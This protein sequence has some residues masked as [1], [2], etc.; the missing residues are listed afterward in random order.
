MTQALREHPQGA[1]VP[2]FALRGVGK[3]YPGVTALADIDL[4]AFPG[5]VLAIC[6]A[7]GAG[8]STMAK[9]IAGQE[10]PSTGRVEI[11]G[12]STPITSPADAE[13]AGVLLM[14]QEP[15]VIEDFTVEENVWLRRISSAGSNRPW[16]RL[17]RGSD[18]RTRGALDAVGLTDV[19]PDTPAR[20]LGPGPR[21]MLAL[22]RTQVV[23]HRV[24]LLDETTASTTEEHFR[25]VLDLV[26]RERAAGVCVVFVSH[27][28]DEVFAMADRIAVMR[29]GRLVDVLRT[30]DTTPGAVIDLMIGESVAALEPLSLPVRPDE[31]PL[32]EV[33]DLAAGSAREVTLRVGPGEVV[34]V[35][36]LV[37]S[38]R[39][40]VARSITGHQPR[41]A[42]RVRLRGRDVDARSPRAALRA[43]LAYLTEDRRREGFVPAF[44][45]GENMTLS[46]LPA[47]AT[48]GVLRGGAERRRVQQLI[49]EFQVKGGPRTLTRT[50]SGGNQQKVILAKWLEAA[51][52]VLVL[53]EPT[54]G[55]D[56]GA[57]ANIYEIVRALAA[58]GR[59]VL[60]VTSE[61]E[62]ALVLC[63]RVL[64]MRDGRLVDEFRPATSTTD[65][66]IRA[67][68]GGD[69]A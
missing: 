2:A 50:L 66:L 44:T 32:L 38:G 7:N 46:T 64:I 33:E 61:A 40:S 54:K 10:Q 30:A 24:L 67:A 13:S 52:Q 36:G 63:N 4:E 55:I 27:R 34:G 48:R 19:S 42:G 26:D 5:E 20:E 6:G 53:D 31:E 56:V 28:M 17:R 16:R 45:N 8:K 3:S 51:P 29:S 58:Q 23:E 1:A 41:L 43:G 14:H 22:S 39:S 37:G 59:G 11:A 60:V 49:G 9:M 35:Y 62:E 15:L 65:D 25:D 68:L 18:P 69:T 21:Q 47:F 57:R 12:R